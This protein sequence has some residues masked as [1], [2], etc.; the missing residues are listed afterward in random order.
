M[1][2][3]GRGAGRELDISVCSQTGSQKEPPP[4]AH[5]NRSKSTVHRGDHEAQ[6]LCG[7]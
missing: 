6:S 3:D 4:R 2:Y 1:W 7:A 5:G